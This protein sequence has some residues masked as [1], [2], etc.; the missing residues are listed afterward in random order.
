MKLL[1]A[2]LLLILA[3]ST[4]NLPLA[5]ALCAAGGAMAV[6]AD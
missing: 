6:I 2:I 1:A 5:L 3:G 4:A